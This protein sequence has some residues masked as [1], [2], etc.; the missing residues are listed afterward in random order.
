MAMMHL[1]SE[2]SPH[3]I[4]AECRLLHELALLPSKNRVVQHNPLNL[5][6]NTPGWGGR[7]RPES[8]AA[9][10][11]NQWQPSTGIDG[12]F[13]PESVA[14]FDRNTHPKRVC[15][16]HITDD[17]VNDAD[18][19]LLWYSESVSHLIDKSPIG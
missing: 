7:F 3:S 19:V 1:L 13:R 18:T 12:R 11:R 15:D 4:I 2:R 9:F 14:I 5:G 16:L 8:V 6:S 17:E 10:N